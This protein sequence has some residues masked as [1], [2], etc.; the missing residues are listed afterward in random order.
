MEETQIQSQDMSNVVRQVLSTNKWKAIF[1]WYS[2][3]NAVWPWFSVEMLSGLMD[4]LWWGLQGLFQSESWPPADIRDTSSTHSLLPERGRG[5]RVRKRWVYCH[6]LH[7]SLCMYC[8]IVYYRDSSNHDGNGLH[9]L[10]TGGQNTHRLK[11][12]SSLGRTLI[13]D[14]LLRP[15]M[16]ANPGLGKRLSTETSI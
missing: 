1:S 8:I 4:L 9:P 14:T 15:C 12:V 3:S 13:V 11:R 16:N 7:I 2:W 5:G 10:A 6:S